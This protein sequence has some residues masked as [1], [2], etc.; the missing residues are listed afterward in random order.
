MQ[1]SATLKPNRKLRRSSKQDYQIQIRSSKIYKIQTHHK[2]DTALDLNPNPCSSLLS[3]RVGNWRYRAL[4]GGDHSW[5]TKSATDLKDLNEKI[6]KHEK[7]RKHISIQV[8]LLFLGKVN[9]AGEIDSG[10]KLL[11]EKHNNQVKK[12][13][14]FV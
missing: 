1:L 3:S 8:H 14:N 6:L 9:I 4:F 7:S 12:N 13:R 2:A 11:L 5:T 10:Y